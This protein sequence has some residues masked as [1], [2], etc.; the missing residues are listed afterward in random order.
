MVDDHVVIGLAP[1]GA[2]GAD[3]QAALD[4]VLAAG[5]GAAASA[6]GDVGILARSELAYA[7]YGIRPKLSKRVRFESGDIVHL[8]P[9][10]NAPELR[11]YAEAASSEAA[12]ALVER[13]LDKLSAQLRG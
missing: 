11:C 2:S 4:R 9:S 12:E 13:H 6:P 3:A 1:A 8:R 5:P 7:A 10:G